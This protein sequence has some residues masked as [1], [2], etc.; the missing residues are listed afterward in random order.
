MTPQDPKLREWLQEWRDLP[1]CDA[2]LHRRVSARCSEVSTTE[3]RRQDWWAWLTGFD[4][5]LHPLRAAV[6]CVFLGILAG[7]ALGEYQASRQRQE[8]QAEMPYRYLTQIDPTRT[9]ALLDSR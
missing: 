5:G 7:A 4:L 9:Y 3:T 8:L 6:W 2:E 1:A